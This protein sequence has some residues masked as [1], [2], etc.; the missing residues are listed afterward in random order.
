MRPGDSIIEVETPDRFQ[1]MRLL[2]VKKQRNLPIIVP[3][4]ASFL[5]GSLKSEV[6]GISVMETA[7]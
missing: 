3:G 2:V 5:G 6:T 4:I 1:K 7:P